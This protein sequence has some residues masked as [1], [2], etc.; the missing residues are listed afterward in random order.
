MVALRRTCTAPSDAAAA[1]TA[2]SAR[3]CTSMISAASP[4]TRR[5]SPYAHTLSAASA[6]SRTQRAGRRSSGALGGCVR[7]AEL[8]HRRRFICCS[9]GWLCCSCEYASV[10]A[11]RVEGRGGPRARQ[12]ESGDVRIHG[13]VRSDG[14]G[15]PGRRAPRCAA[16]RQQACDRAGYSPGQRWWVE[17]SHNAHN[18]E[19]FARGTIV[20]K[21]YSSASLT[22]SSVFML[23]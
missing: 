23:V 19:P 2:A 18:Y 5:D 9:R 12:R 3:D 20:R 21:S 17:V 15:A 13:S 16:R 11:L 4:T 22:D 14:G 1:A 8:L 7:A 10:A 6:P